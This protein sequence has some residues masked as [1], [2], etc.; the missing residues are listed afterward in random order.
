[1]FDNSCIFVTSTQE[2][3]IMSY[4]TQQNKENLFF[5]NNKPCKKKNRK[6]ANI[7]PSITFLWYDNFGEK[8]TP[9]H[10]NGMAAIPKIQRGKD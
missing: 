9:L 3:V 8:Q 7:W 4:A 2:L 1:M 10:R 5:D 6:L